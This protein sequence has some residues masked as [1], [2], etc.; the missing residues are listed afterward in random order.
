LLACAVA[1]APFYRLLVRSPRPLYIL[2]AVSAVSLAGLLCV[3]L[4]AMNRRLARGLPRPVRFLIL[5]ARDLRRFSKGRA[6]REQF[7][8]S[9]LIVGSMSVCFTVIGLSLAQPIGLWTSLVV[10]PPVIVSMHLPMS[11]AGW[12]TREVGAVVLLPLA[13][14][15]AEAALVMSVLYGLLILCSGIAGLLLWHFSFQR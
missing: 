6:F 15:P 5:L 8:T 1:L 4:A 3:I 14:V 13:G 12:G 2:A 9:A 7:V 11:Y 10:V